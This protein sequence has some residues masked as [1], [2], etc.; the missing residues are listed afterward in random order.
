MVTSESSAVVTFENEDVLHRS[1]NSVSSPTDL[2]G[3]LSSRHPVGVS[4]HEARP[5]R[6]GPLA[7]FFHRYR[8]FACV[9]LLNSHQETNDLFSSIMLMI[10]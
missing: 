1:D 3:K 5:K 2:H 9:M 6:L 4:T 10:V 7:S 8:V